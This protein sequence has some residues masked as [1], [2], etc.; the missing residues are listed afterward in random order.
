MFTAKCIIVKDC[1]TSISIISIL[2][3][4]PEAF[5][6]QTLHVE[7][8]K[9]TS[10]HQNSCTAP[11]QRVQSSALHIFRAVSSLV[12]F[13]C[14]C[15]LVCSS[16]HN[17]CPAPFLISRAIRACALFDNPS[18]RVARQSVL[19]RCSTAFPSAFGGACT[20]STRSIHKQ[21][22]RSVATLRVHCFQR[23]L[24]SFHSVIKYMLFQVLCNCWAVFRGNHH[25][26][27]EVTILLTSLKF[28][29][30]NVKVCGPHC[31]Q[32]EYETL[33]NCYS[34]ANNS[35]WFI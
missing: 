15:G 8:S 3:K 6:R 19:A 2:W 28:S 29:S 22:R 27:Q 17:L 20:R 24:Q 5:C 12:H 25:S 31:Y 7:V 16:R 13:S 11:L 23:Y 30:D 33:F 4:S 26:C 34:I 21:W 1:E 14:A 35:T 10:S 18:L 9:K 32:V